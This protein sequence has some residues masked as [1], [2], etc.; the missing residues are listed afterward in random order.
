MITTRGPAL[1]PGVPGPRG[2]R[3]GVAT[4]HRKIPR[5]RQRSDTWSLWSLWSLVFWAWIDCVWSYFVVVIVVKPLAVV[6]LVV[7]IV[8]LMVVVVVVVVVRFDNTL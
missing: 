3:S 8:V 2:R 5:T 7:V 4:F 1:P 6:V